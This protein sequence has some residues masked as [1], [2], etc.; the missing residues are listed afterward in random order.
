[1][2]IIHQAQ[3]NDNIY[4]N[5]FGNEKENG[6]NVAK[7]ITA[8]DVLNH[9]TLEPKNENPKIL[10]ATNKSLPN[11]KCELHVRFHNIR[12]ASIFVNGFAQYYWKDHF[13]LIAA[14]DMSRERLGSMSVAIATL[15]KSSASGMTISCI[16]MEKRE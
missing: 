15:K 12:T 8:K 10:V 2:T 6:H 5:V 7:I 13:R 4:I 1:M 16:S 14:H 11:K 3:F 9:P